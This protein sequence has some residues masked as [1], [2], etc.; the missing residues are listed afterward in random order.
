MYGFTQSYN[1]TVSAALVISHFI[2]RL[3]QE[4]FSW[5]LSETEKLD[6]KLAWVRQ[7]LRSRQLAEKLEEK[8]FSLRSP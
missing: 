2:E 3:H 4:N 8:F 7:T 5:R 1:I 6:L